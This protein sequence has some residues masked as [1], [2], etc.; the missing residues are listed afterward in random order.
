MFVLAGSFSTED[1]KSVRSRLMPF[2]TT[3]ISPPTNPVVTIVFS[4][5]TLI[6]SGPNGTCEV[7]V[8]R[9]SREHILQVLLIVKRPNLPPLPIPLVGGHLTAPFN[10]R[11]Q[12]DPA[13]A[14]D[15]VAFAQPG[16]FN[17]NPS[18]DDPLD[19]R[20][21]INLRDASLHPGA[22]FNDGARPIV[23]LKTGILYTPHLSH[24]SVVPT[25]VRPGSTPVV[26]NR[27]AVNLAAAIILAG[28]RLLLN[29]RDMGE[30]K[31]ILLPRDS[32]IPH[33]NTTYTICFIN[34]PAN[35]STLPH[36][37]L[38]EMYKV[39][40]VANAE[41]P[42]PQRWSLQYTQPFGRTDEI[43]CLTGLLDP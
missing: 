42:R 2:A 40:H 17:R 15:F 14:G 5:L 12:P 8:N 6:R 36:D 19:Y 7:G 11:F 27:I 24:P 29:W 41:I 20:W 4:G 37:E 39:L 32:D 31:N 22:D 33:P 23:S 3:S 25:L 38:A 13:A 9:L 35:F 21:A 1:Q 16:A 34:D 26:L 43:P 28:R 10:I 30:D 18:T